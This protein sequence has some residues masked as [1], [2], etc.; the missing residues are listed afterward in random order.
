MTADRDAWLRLV[1]NLNDAREALASGNVVQA[2]A[3]VDAAIALDGGFLA[4]QS[5][6]DDI[7]ARLP[8]N[9]VEVPPVH[10]SDEYA[11]AERGPRQTIGIRAAATVGLLIPLGVAAFWPAPA[12]LRRQ[13][14]RSIAGESRASSPT[15]TAALVK[16]ASPLPV[17]LA[18]PP[19]V[20]TSATAAP[21]AWTSPRLTQLDVRPHWR[22]SAI[23]VD[24]A[25]LLRDLEEGVSELRIGA[26]TNHSDAIF[27]GAI[28]DGEWASVGSSLKPNGV[29]W[30]IRPHRPGI[31]GDA[32]FTTAAIS[33]G[34]API[35]RLRYSAGYTATEYARRRS[36]H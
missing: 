19:V 24:D 6:R 11:G 13:A 9:L 22:A 29:V 10:D 4:A 15:P 20:A 26:V 7:L 28:D 14:S 25:A 16:K 23:H 31:V 35:K 2:L 18:R 3:D 12:S 33:A 1:G 8:A 27:V 36:R 21:A 34:F 32:A 17:F 30:L 5:L